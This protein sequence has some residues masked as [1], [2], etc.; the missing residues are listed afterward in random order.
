[1]RPTVL[2]LA[3]D[4]LFLYN[5]TESLKRFKSWSITAAN[6]QEALE[7]CSNHDVD[8]ALL[9]IRSQ[10]SDTLQVLASLKKYQPETEVILLS[11]SKHID[12]AMEGMQQGANDDISVPFDLEAFSK[13][14]Q[15]ALRRRRA[16]LKARHSLLDVFENTMAAAAFAE[17]GEF[18]IAN[19]IQL[20][21]TVL[22]KRS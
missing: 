3:E 8:L 21:N 13:K 15:S 7:V 10:G 4:V 18:D 22:K 20:E 17:A 16:S 2:L 6:K 19:N 11:D 1:M 14:I 5:L 12:V 9:D